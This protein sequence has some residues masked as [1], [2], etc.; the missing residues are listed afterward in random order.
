MT[1]KELFISQS[2]M[3]GADV[4]VNMLTCND[5]VAENKVSR[6]DMTS[7]VTAK[8]TGADTHTHIRMPTHS[9]NMYG[10]NLCPFSTNTFNIKQPDVWTPGDSRSKLQPDHHRRLI[11][12]P[13]LCISKLKA[14]NISIIMSA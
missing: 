2:L 14:V 11:P 7:T 8:S 9:I 4:N 6:A 10:I 13:R 12:W 5:R 3:V 1:E